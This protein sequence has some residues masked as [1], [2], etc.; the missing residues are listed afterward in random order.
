MKVRLTFMEELLGTAP[1]DPEIYGSYV[2]SKALDAGKIEAEIASIGVDGVIEKGKTIFSRRT[3]VAK[4]HSDESPILWDYQIKGFFKDACGMLSRVVGTKSPKL[5]AYKKIIDGLVFVFPR[6][7]LLHLPEGRGIGEC[8]RPLRIQGAQGERIALACSE[9]VPKGTFIEIEITSM[10]LRDKT[11]EK[12][13][14]KEDGSKKKKDESDS[15]ILR[16]CICE[17]LEYGKLRGIGQWRNSGKGRF[18]YEIIG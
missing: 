11:S 18:S 9:T 8:Q 14:K 17:W 3:D 12:E 6:E 10:V 7:I 15:D 4:L 16:E 1:G 2:A 5:T 13:S